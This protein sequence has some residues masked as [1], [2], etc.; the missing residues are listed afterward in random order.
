VFNNILH[1]I[2]SHIWWKSCMWQDKYQILAG[3]TQYS[4]WDIALQKVNCIR[5]RAAGVQFSSLRRQQWSLVFRFKVIFGFSPF[6]RRHARWPGSSPQSKWCLQ[7]DKRFL[8]I[9]AKP[10]RGHEADALAPNG[11]YN[12]ASAGISFIW[13]L[14]YKSRFQMMR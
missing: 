9:S 10:Q 7:A 1:P 3:E 4:R 6:L 2:Y 5:I 8:K 11:P 14:K 13:G 12:A